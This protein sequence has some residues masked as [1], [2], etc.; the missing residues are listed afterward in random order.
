MTQSVVRIQE[1]APTREKGDALYRQ[2]VERAK[3]A[4]TAFP[5]GPERDALMFLPDYVIARDR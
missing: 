3:K 1:Q 5:A 4:L 2:L